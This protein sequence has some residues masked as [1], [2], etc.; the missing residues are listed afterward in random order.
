M[1]SQQVLEKYST[2]LAITQTKSIT[3]AILCHPHRNSGHQENQVIKDAD[4]AGG[5]KPFLT[6]D[7]IEIG[8]PIVEY[9]RER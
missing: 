1:Q 2:F 9:E 6:A 8:P 4:K 7:G 3:F 5:K